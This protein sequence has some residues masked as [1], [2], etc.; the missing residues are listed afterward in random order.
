MIRRRHALLVLV[1]S[2]VGAMFTIAFAAEA[3]QAKTCPI[4]VSD[5]LT[6]LGTSCANLSRNTSCYGHD[7]VQHTAFTQAVPADFYT[8]PGDRADLSLTAT[9]Q[10]GPFDLSQEIWGL[11]VMNVNANL[12]YSLSPKGVVYVQFG[13]VEVESAV[14]TDQAV[15]LP[16]TGTTVATTSG[17]NLLTWPA[18]SISGHASD[19][20]T[21][22]PEGSSL[23]VDAVNPAG[24]FVRAVYQNRV[25]WVSLSALDSSVD[26]SGLPS[27]GPDDM[28]PMQSF[29]YRTG[30]GGTSCEQAPSLLFIQGPQNASVDLRV[31]QQPIRIESTIVLRSIP[32]GDQ[33]GNQL[34]LIVLSGLAV[35]YPDTPQQIIIPPGFKTTI[36]LCDQFESLGIEGDADEKATCGTW[37]Q[38]IPLTP[39]ELNQLKP[40]EGI[41][42]NIINYP[43]I[44]PIIIN[45][46]GAGGV[47]SQLVFPDQSA[48]DAAIA[49]CQ[50]GTLPQSICQYLGIS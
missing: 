13:G 37:S 18:P 12:P 9:I 3:Q 22:V 26:L 38:P 39:D 31:F 20:V 10:T 30:I 41:P 21:P 47:P 23:S 1:I 33:L 43:I 2:L 40:I 25:G 19:V 7:N 27:I 49:A 36:D 24:D 46:S 50:A 15:V 5:S 48:L 44:I 32:P 35:V 14:P 11:N 8:Q 45:T 17:T 29:Y 42:G 34:E 6:S 16:E 4:V 28:T